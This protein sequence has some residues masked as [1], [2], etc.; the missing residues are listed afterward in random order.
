MKLL[1]HLWFAS[2]GTTFRFVLGQSYVAYGTFAAILFVAFGS[3][4]RPLMDPAEIAPPV[5][6]PRSSGDRQSIASFTPWPCCMPRRA[7]A[8][9]R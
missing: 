9:N 4:F 1:A 2:W 6:R 8:S 5:L 7:I 3:P